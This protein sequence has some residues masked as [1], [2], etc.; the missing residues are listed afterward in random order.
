MTTGRTIIVQGYGAFVGK[1]SERLVIR[2]PRIDPSEPLAA[3]TAFEGDANDPLPP[4]WGGA[5][6]SASPVRATATE[7]VP[8]SVTDAGGPAASA[9][10]V[11]A[12][13]A[14]DVTPGSERTEAPATH[15]RGSRARGTGTK[16]P[17]AMI[18]E[19]V[20]LH[21]VAE[22]VLPAR[23]VMVSVELLAEA[24]SRGIAVSFLSFSGTPWGLLSSPTMT[25][26]V[27]TRRE[28]LRAYDQA[29]GANVA[30][31]IIA[32]KLRNQR[33][34]LATAVK[35]VHD[36]DT[37]KQ[38]REAI[39]ALDR[40]RAQALRVRGD[41][42]ESVRPSL[43]GI[44]GAA[45]H[46]YCQCFARLCGAQ[47]GFVGRKFEG[48]L[49]GVNAMLNYGYAILY[50]RVWA[51]TLRAGLDP[52]GGFV[53]ADRPG[54]PSLVLD[55]VEELRAPVVDRAVLA[56][57]RLRCPVGQEED[58]R[59][60]EATRKAVAKAVL[61]RLDAPVKYRGSKTALGHVIQAQA[62]SLATNLRGEGE[63]RPFTMYW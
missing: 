46:V 36:V 8:S 14:A 61:E 31:R 19:E 18:E 50:S 40:A 45:A 51:A 33:G 58:G 1:R 23:G 7:G 35:T 6:A 30:R 21:D 3:G 32:G 42:V 17:R 59:L 52:F 4:S 24:A 43:L 11:R 39:A 54:R 62:R 5:G 56:H 29:L 27:R 44:E 2:T 20:P 9:S 26:T 37:A 25:A 57:V 15:P 16:P 22:I 34:L 12:S 55:L 38:V 49:D 53:H 63:W 41:C 60:D 47:S 48:P 28:Q 10:P 13:D